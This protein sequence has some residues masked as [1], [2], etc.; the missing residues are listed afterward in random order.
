MTEAG[1]YIV[2]GDRREGFGEAPLQREHGSGLGGSEQ[3]LDLGPA[4]LDGI[5]VR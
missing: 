4:F 2:G 1:L 5:E 3:L